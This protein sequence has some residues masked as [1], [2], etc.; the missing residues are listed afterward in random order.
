MVVVVCIRLLDANES[1]SGPLYTRLR[2]GRGGWQQWR[3]NFHFRM[4]C[5]ITTFDRPHTVQWWAIKLSA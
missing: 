2:E 3:L 1:V 5:T 4:T